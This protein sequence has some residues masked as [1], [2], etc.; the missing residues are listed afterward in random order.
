MQ[1]LRIE[2]LDGG[3]LQRTLLN[4]REVC[5]D[6]EILPESCIVPRQFSRTAD[7][8][9]AKSRYAEVWS[10]QPSPGGGNGGTMDVCIKVIKSEKVL[11][12]GE[13][14]HRLLWQHIKRCLRDSMGTSRYG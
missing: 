3:L 10:G 1:V 5:G 7:H 14:S 13:F 6:R 9:L 12:V 4:L 2:G 11:K 8:P